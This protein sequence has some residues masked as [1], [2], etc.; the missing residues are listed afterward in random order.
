MWE[1]IMN[2]LPQEFNRSIESIDSEDALDK[3][4]RI[5][6]RELHKYV[7]G[8]VGV[9]TLAIGT[10]PIAMNRVAQKEKF[11]SYK[12]HLKSLTLEYQP[13][14]SS[15]TSIA[16]ATAQ[17]PERVATESAQTPATAKT[18]ERVVTQSEHT[19]TRFMKSTYAVAYSPDGEM[20]AASTEAGEIDY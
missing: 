15:A 1:L 12:S 10:Y 19:L 4:I 14:E 16:T 2:D 3:P 9:F 18:P 13:I 11:V 8:L 20:L 6:A 5:S 7:L 17:T